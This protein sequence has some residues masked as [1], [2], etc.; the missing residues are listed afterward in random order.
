MPTRAALVFALLL[1]ASAAAQQAAA[2]PSPT[3]PPA[4]SDPAAPVAPAEDKRV[5]G[6]LPNYRTAE[7]A[8]P[9]AP[10]TPKQKMTIAAKDSFD[11]PLFLTGA[12]FA[13]LYQ[14]EDQNPSFGEGLK[15]YAKRYGTAYGDQMI[16][17]MMTEGLWPILL[18]EDPRY[19]RLGTGTV[20]RR[21]W[22]A[23]TRI[24]V[25][26]TDAGGTRFNF[27]EVIGNSVATAIS[28]AYYPDT[29]DVRDNVEK[30]AIQLG[31][32]SFS[33]VAKEFWPDIKRKLFHRGRSGQDGP[34]Q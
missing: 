7:S 22:Y 23:A 15:G 34:Q 8:V 31:T 29:R 21:L 25:T 14:I 20:P 33:Q 18:K 3:P 10:I 24:F 32:D 9:F 27:S 30:L 17:N 28:N 2:Q 16:G 13:G 1:P 19:F 12:A 11:W 5:F 6:V 4:A 26:R